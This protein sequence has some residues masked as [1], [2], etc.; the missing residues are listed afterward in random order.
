MPR[1]PKI[2]LKIH[3]AVDTAFVRISHRP[4]AL[5]GLLDDRRIVDYDEQGEILGS[6]FL[7]VHA[8]V[9]LRELP[10]H[11]ELARLF[12]DNEIPASA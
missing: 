11:D 8:G 10:Y 7:D 6:E 9:D 5:T 12:G 3:N 2:E 1:D 4:V